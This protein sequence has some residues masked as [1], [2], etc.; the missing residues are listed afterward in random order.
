MPRPRPT[1]KRDVAVACAGG[2]GVG[3]VAAVVAYW[4]WVTAG[5]PTFVGVA[6][7]PG[8]LIIVAVVHVLLARRRRARESDWVA[9][10]YTAAVVGAVAL[11][12]LEKALRGIYQ[13]LNTTVW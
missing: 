3:A 1:I 8:S 12:A 13:E 6:V 2:L 11:L 7:I 4:S 10:G 9:L 5:G